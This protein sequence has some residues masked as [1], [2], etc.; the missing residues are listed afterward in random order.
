ML[1]VGDQLGPYLIVA[2]LGAGGMGEVYRATDIRLQRTVALKVLSRALNQRGDMRQRFEREARAI[3][4]LNHPNICTLH[5]IGHQDGIDYIVMEC[6]EG[7]TIETSLKRGPLALSNVLTY[8]VQ[9]ANALD[10]AHRAGIVHRDLKPGNVM[11]T[12]QGVKLLDFGLAK[13]QIQVAA[14]DE[15]LALT[16]P[17]EYAL[18]SEPALLGTL[19]Y[20]APEQ[21][22]ARGVDARTDI[23][24][25]GSTLYEMLTARKAFTAKTRAGLIAAIINTDPP[26]FES[27]GLT[28]PT[29]V[30]RIIRTCLA[31]NPDDRWQSARDV[32]LELEFIAES[33]PQPP[34][35][36]DLSTWKLLAW[37]AGAIICGLLGTILWMSQLR[38]LNASL[39]QLEI[40]APDKSEF[41]DLGCAIS[42]DGRNVAFVAT[43]E[44]KAH[45]WLRSLDAR[46]ARALQGTDEAQF[47]FW[48]PDSRSIGFF[49]RN[50]LKS[51]D[52]NSN[53]SRVIATT[54]NGR[55]GSW[56]PEGIIVYSPKLTSRLW[57]VPATGGEPVPATTLDNAHGD[58]RHNYPQFLPDG[59]HFIFFAHG[60]DRHRSGPQVGSLDDPAR[61]MSIPHLK[62]NAFQAVYAASGNRAQG[63]LIYVRDSSLVAQRF[64][65]RTFRLEGETQSI[66]SR[67]SFNVASSP[68]FLNF[69]ASATGALVDGGSMHAKN[70]MVW[71][72]RDGSLIDVLAREGD[73]ITP[74]VSP[75][76]SRIAV[77]KPDA[78]SGDYD[79]WIQNVRK[80]RMS[81]FT[82]ERGLNYYPVWTPDGDSIIYSSDS[83]GKLSLFVKAAAGSGKPQL[84]FKA[85]DGSALA[86]DVSPDGKFLLFVQSGD[87][88]RGD[89]WVMPLDKSTAPFPFLKTPAGEQ[90]PQFSTGTQRGQWI[91]YTSDESGVEQ[92][93]VRQFSGG[94]AAEAKWQISLSGG[95][96]PLWGG[97]GSDIIYLAPDGKLMSAP[98]RF[99]KDSVEAGSPQ[100]LF[101]A[102]LPTLV[103]SRYPYDV[104]SDGQRFLMLNIA[105]GLSPGSLT[106][107]LNWTG[108]LKR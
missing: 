98:I 80:N 90:H 69:T 19:P 54:A 86:Y 105:R 40:T 6:L 103:F 24:A 60:S 14:D 35:Y 76:G 85:D 30:D 58:A 87:V 37:V 56:S 100:P 104:S 11:L 48:S 79:I 74:R 10:R 77:A 28:I 95:K 67:D 75:D 72:R 39:V 89:I 82:F 25:F 107:I 2:P 55:G 106:L 53:E 81:R 94:P 73:Y 15:P 36:R 99:S 17:S 5:D 9:I 29:A 62:G 65:T 47:P 93:Y 16:L 51:F 63:Y 3:S 41:S 50:K 101:D 21:V 84:L 88:D 57:K 92:I 12:K 71:R 1:S 8:G 70:E 66:V 61:I 59:E 38:E 7:Q 43:T 102:G 4:Q 26:T 108:L 18:P 78:V 91:A 44:G 23:F 34:L 97:A 20:M 49:T 45:L 64:N 68:G 31:K 32:A 42:P 33:P 52:L 27:V 83:V 13:L 22:E 46:N 96:Y